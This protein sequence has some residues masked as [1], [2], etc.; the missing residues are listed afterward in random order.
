VILKKK[1]R[2]K[3]KM[4]KRIA[5]ITAVAFLV[6]AVVGI[7]STSTIAI[8]Q[9]AQAFVDPEPDLAEPKAPM[10]ASAS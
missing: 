4:E 8:I 6:T 5:A 1:E 2:E 9:S 3:D 7:F 10:A